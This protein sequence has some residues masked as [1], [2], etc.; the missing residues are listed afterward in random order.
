MDQVRL[1]RMEANLKSIQALHSAQIDRALLDAIRLVKQ[2]L[3]ATGSF[4]CP[5]DPERFQELCSYLEQEL[6][7]VL[8]HIGGRYPVGEIMELR[9]DAAN[10]D[11]HSVCADSKC[12]EFNLA[13]AHI[14]LRLE[15]LSR[16]RAGEPVRTH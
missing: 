8:C 10:T 11:P 1:R 3:H 4:S 14:Q 5:Q 12:R 9:E 7:A 13:L 6:E 15:K 16:G 2:M